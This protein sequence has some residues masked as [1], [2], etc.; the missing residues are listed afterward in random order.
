MLILCSNAKISGTEFEPL[1]WKDLAFFLV[2]QKHID[3]VGIN[4][5]ALLMKSS[6]ER[7]GEA[8]MPF[9][10]IRCISSDPKYPQ[11]NEAISWLHLY[12][13]LFGVAGNRFSKFYFMIH[14]HGNH[15]I[16]AIIDDELPGPIKIY[17]HDSNY[18]K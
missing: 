8:N 12:D 11:V 3:A 2:P 1:N 18:S 9:P 15:F 10:D 4:S 5:L 13:C 6:V 14:Q 7:L 16:T 17:V